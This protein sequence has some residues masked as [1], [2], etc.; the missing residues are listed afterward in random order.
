MKPSPRKVYD[1]PARHWAFL[2]QISDD[3]FEGQYF[4][5][6]EAGQR[7]SDA[8]GL[9]N[10]LKQLR[11]GITETISAFANSNVEGGLLVIGIASNGDVKGINHLTEQQKNSL[12]NIGILLHNQAAEA[13]LHGCQDGAG[14]A[15][16]I[17]LI[18]TPYADRGICE[19]PGSVPKAWE[20][21]GSQNVPVTQA[22]RDRLRDRKS[23]S[24]FENT[25]CCPYDRSD[26]SD[27]ILAEFRKVFSPDATGDFSDERLLYEAGALIRRDEE[28]WFTHAGLLFFGSNPQ[29]VLPASY[30]RLLRFGVVSEDFAKRGLPSFDQKFTGPVTKQIREA[31]TFF[32]ES[33]FFKRYQK[34]LAA[35]G[36]IEEPELPPTVIDEAIVNAVA[37]RDY[38][39]A[40]PIECEA[41]TDAFVVKNPGRMTQ[42][43]ADLPSHFSLAEVALDS[44][45]RNPKLLEWL[46]LMRDPGGVAYVQAISEGTKQM[47]TA[48]EDLGLPAPSY[49]LA[50]NETLIKIESRAEEREAA[51]LAANEDEAT[52]FG[53]LFLLRLRRQDNPVGYEVFGSRYGEIVKTLR[54]ALKGNGWHIDRDGFSR[55][56]AHRRGIELNTP[57]EVRTILRFYPAYELQIRQ[58]HRYYYLCVDYRCLAL[59]VRK[60][61]VVKQHFARRDLEGHRCIADKGG[62]REGR[63]SEFGD[64]FAKVQFFD[65][66]TEESVSV[67]DVI[68]VCSMTM[69]ESMLKQEGSSFDLTAALRRHS[70]VAR[71]DAA[72][73]R[74]EKTLTMV[75]HLAETVFPLR[76]SDLEVDIVS[77]PIHLS[78]R[79]RSSKRELIVRRLPEPTVEFRQH[80]L[81]SDVRAGITKYGAYDGEPQQI[82]LVPVCVSSMREGMEQLIA[83]LIGGRYK[84]LGSERTFATKFSYST[85]IAVDHVED[86]R[87]EVERLLAQR[88][89]DQTNAR[90]R[91]LFLVHT[92]EEG[93]SRDDHTA[94]YYVNKRLLLERGAPCQMVDTPTLRNPDWKDLNLALNICAKCGVRPWVLPDAI[95]EADFF[96]GLSYTQSRDG[97]RIMG[98]AS[99]FNR[100]GRWEFYRG[101][102]SYFDFEDRNIRLAGLVEETLTRLESRLSSTPRVVFQYSAKLSQFDREAILKAA[103]KIRPEGTYTFVWINSHHNVRFYDRRP[104]TDGSLR[105]GSYVEASANKLYLSTTG[106]NPFRRVMGTPKPLEVSAWV[107]RP[108]GGDRRPDLRVLALQVLSLTKLNWASTDAF[109][110]EPITLKYA[111][112][113]AYLTAAFLRQSEPF[114]LHPSLETTP[115]FI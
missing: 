2:T 89:E 49:R 38:R 15:N 85:I 76:C 105:R 48:M 69:L 6:K 80:Q 111:G 1:D 74:A 21:F 22:T 5:R 16:A 78:E 47:V 41:Y 62:W 7:T 37:H 34:R 63:L 33:A 39:T 45:P 100:Y 110:G 104:E 55:I 18:F 99:V 96:I 19:T 44:M 29:R 114:K 113:I 102:T 12:T 56:L 35:G 108:V 10:Q 25:F 61:A 64:E 60:L 46:K 90:T 101:N 8:R 94:P 95:P 107:E 58:Y 88:P 40:I 59:N 81:S 28:Y 86:I 71:P 83:R 84:Y 30:I 106:Y 98:F 54:D 24:D 51:L 67:G 11:E 3:H 91:S 23:L 115:W 65:T 13:K 79:Q 14:Q 97:R 4:D 50:L 66:D 93:Y 112:D 17:C 53:N 73:E 26:L 27:D 72:R 20:R 43:A 42:R 57:V 36:F 32:R 77:D 70:L 75:N 9:G 87:G 103:R 109:C 52:E 92:P 68:P 82:E 31:R